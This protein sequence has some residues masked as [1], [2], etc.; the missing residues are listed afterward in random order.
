MIRL[1]INRSQYFYVKKR[2]RKRKRKNQIQLKVSPL[3][4]FK[5]LTEFQDR[6]SIM[7]Y[8]QFMV[9]FLQNKEYIEIY[10]TPAEID[11]ELDS[12]QLTQSSIIFFKLLRKKEQRKF[13][14]F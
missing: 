4:A 6:E 8:A 2:K 13:I 14:W 5:E 10:N 3:I 11:F 9:G 12:M 1:I 7:Q